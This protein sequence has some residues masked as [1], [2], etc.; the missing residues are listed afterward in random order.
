MKLRKWQKKFDVIGQLGRGGNAAVYHVREKNT[1]KEFALKELYNKNKE[2]KCRFEDEINIITQNCEKIEGIIPIIESSST[3]YW[4]TMPIA[5]PILFHIKKSKEEIKDII[6]GIIQLSKTLS[7]LHTKQ[8]SHRDIKPSNIYFYSNRYCLGDF[9]LVDFPDNDN[10]FTKSNNGLGAIFT[11]APEMKRDPKRADGRSADVFSLAKTMWM[12]LSDNERGFD[13]PYNFLDQ[14]HSLRFMEKYKNVHIVELEEVLGKSTSNDPNL[15]YDIDSFSKQLEAWLN[16]Y[17][18]TEKSEAAEWNFL[19]KYL[20]GENPPEST[21]WRDKAKIIH[22]L[23]IIGTLPAYNHMLFSNGG[24]LTF[25]SAEIA[26]EDGC[27]YIYDTMGFC[28]LLKPKCLCFEGFNENYDWNYFLLEL[29]ELL[30]VF[31]S[32]SLDY[33]FLVEDLPSHYVSARY[34]QY[35]VYD[36]DLGNSLPEGYKIVTRYLKGKILIVLGNGP[37]NN[38][39]ATYDGRHGLCSNGEFRTYIE[40][41]ITALDKCIKYN[42]EF[43]KNDILNLEAFS[44]NPFHTEEDSP[45]DNVEN[46]IEKYKKMVEFIN[47]NYSKW[48]L[49]NILPNNDKSSNIAFYI[50]FKKDVYE[51]VPA[52]SPYEKLYLCSDGKIKKIEKGSFS[53][54]YYVYDRE[55]AIELENMCSEF[56]AEKCV[57]NNCDK[58]QIYQHFFSIE[59][60]KNG[61][62]IH[63]FTKSEIESVMRSADDRKDNMLVIDENGYAQVIDNKNNIFLYPVRHESWDAGNMYVGKYSSLNTLDYDYISSLQ[64]WLNYLKYERAI[65]VDYL[66]ENK[67]EEELIKAIKEYY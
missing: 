60:K 21:V 61:K 3:E 54:V 46:A 55:E 30:P 45:V 66:S 16:I 2:K 9:G 56:L 19:N 37:Y 38:I 1:N 24:G 25:K 22:V 58:P 29:D 26:N 50:T 31:D 40:K 44:K 17:E 34:A 64:G 10:D 43:Q 4:Y 52:I 27:I 49:K 67:N 59:L 57:A 20:F 18:D 65:Y 51:S 32:C 6:K 15:R 23:N 62:P 63:L 48:S 33:E 28:F 41:L 11:I 7:F 5:E 47:K 14:S 53:E 8:I 42:S 39:S 13:G 35:G 36:Y 12:L